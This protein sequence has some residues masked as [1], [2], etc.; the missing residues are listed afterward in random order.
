[1]AAA[2]ALPVGTPIVFM[3]FPFM[4][5]PPFGGWRRRTNQYR[6]QRFRDYC[7]GF[8]FFER[9]FLRSG[10]AP[11]GGALFHLEDFV[12]DGAHYRVVFLVVLEEVGHIQESIPLESNVHECRLHSGQYARDAPFL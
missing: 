7:C 10:L 1:S 2:A 3:L 5:I 8:R 4:F 11:A 9:S 12:L 6:T